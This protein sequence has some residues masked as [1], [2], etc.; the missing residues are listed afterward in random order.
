MID[1][2]K[3]IKGLKCLAQKQAPTANPCKGCGYIN[4]PSF[5]ICVIDIASDALELLKEQEEVEPKKVY[6]YGK[7]AWYGLVCVCADCNAKW[8]SGKED[9][10]FCPKCGRSVK[11]E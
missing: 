1:G 8:M 9:T 5:A 2:E 4:R 3:V 7:D 11:W 10:H 6:L